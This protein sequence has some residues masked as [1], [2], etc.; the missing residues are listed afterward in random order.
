MSRVSFT[1][2]AAGVLGRPRLTVCA[3]PLGGATSGS[4]C[5]KGFSAEETSELMASACDNLVLS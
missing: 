1:Y 2:V 5:H 3:V 4:M